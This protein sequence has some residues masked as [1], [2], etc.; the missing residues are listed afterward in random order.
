MIHTLTKATAV[1]VSSTILATLSVNAVDIHGR[2]VT[3]YLGALLLSAPQE[4]GICPPGMTVVE[5]ALTPYCVDVYEVSTGD[6]CPYENPA[7]ND[8]TSL[9]IANA[10]CM[11]VSKPNIIPWRNITQPQAARMCE[12]A[13]KRLLTAGEWYIASLGTPDEYHNLG[14]EQC[15]FESCRWSREYGG[16]NA[17][18]L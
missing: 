1:I 5:S 13:G 10:D 14:D 2:A 16:R 12:R 9:N 8:E 3:T 7:T 18:C 15:I 17:V 6:G 4:S 11:P